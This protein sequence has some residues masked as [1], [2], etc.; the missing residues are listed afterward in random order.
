MKLHPTLCLI[1]ELLEK[2]ER[3]EKSLT[4]EHVEDKLSKSPYIRSRISYFLVP[5]T[6]QASLL[7][8]KNPKEE[9]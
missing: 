1:M 9:S 6:P 3:F 4:A 7:S 5:P 2:E 8:A